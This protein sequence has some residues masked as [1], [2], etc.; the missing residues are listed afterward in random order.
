MKYGIAVYKQENIVIGW[1]AFFLHI[2][3]FLSIYFSA[4]DSRFSLVCINQNKKK[5][6]GFLKIF[7]SNSHSDKYELIT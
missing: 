7:L 2:S 1:N 3:D 4:D 5:I 6:P